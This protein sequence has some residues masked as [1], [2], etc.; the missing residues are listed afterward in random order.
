M[1]EIFED[2][3]SAFDEKKQADSKIRN[4]ERNYKKYFPADKNSKVLDIGIGMGEMLQCMKNWGYMNYLGIDISPSIIKHCK[5]KRINLV[6]V[7][8]RV[9]VWREIFHFPPTWSINS[10][11]STRFVRVLM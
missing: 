8:L 5:G 7:N 11:C 9:G 6:K 10:K 1:K 2:Y 3:V 4:F